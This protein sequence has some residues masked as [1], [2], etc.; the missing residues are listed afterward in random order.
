MT[1]F[2]AKYYLH[3]AQFYLIEYQYYFYVALGILFFIYLKIKFSKR[4][5]LKKAKSKNYINNLNWRDFEKIIGMYYKKRG[6]KVALHGG[7][8][9]D[10]GIDLLLRKKG[11]KIIVQCKHW[12]KNSIG[13]AI[14]REMYGVMVS[15]NA[16]KVFVVASGRFTKE[17]YAFA[18]GKPISLICGNRLNKMLND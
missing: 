2:E 12:K 7:S 14:I 15:E 16:D 13:V 8:G 11:E 18:K 10:N 1:L 17:A 3:V 5:S 6:Y 9:G 4:L